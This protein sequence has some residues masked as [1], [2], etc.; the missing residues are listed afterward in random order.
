MKWMV[1]VASEANLAS[2]LKMHVF[3]CM[4]A[5]SRHFWIKIFLIFTLFCGTS[6]GFTKTLKTFATSFFETI[7][8]I[9]VELVIIVLHYDKFSH[10]KI[11]FT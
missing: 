3:W 5:A 2:F 10:T 11:T 6:T 7:R 4:I 9:Y 8:G 1:V